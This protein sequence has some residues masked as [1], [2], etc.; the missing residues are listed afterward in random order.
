MIESQAIDNI[1]SDV[2]VD[3]CVRSFTCIFS[4]RTCTQALKSGLGKRMMASSSTF[5][6]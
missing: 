6:Q 5:A 1:I 2:P 3:G 4:V